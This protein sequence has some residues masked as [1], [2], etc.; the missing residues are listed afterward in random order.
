MSRDNSKSA[1]TLINSQPRQSPSQ[2]DEYYK[3]ER[4]ELVRRS[5]GTLVV[6]MI[7]QN[8]KF[9]FEPNKNYQEARWFAWLKPL[10]NQ[11]LNGI[12]QLNVSLISI[13]NVFRRMA[14]NCI[15]PYNELRVKINWRDKKSWRL[16]NVWNRQANTFALRNCEGFVCFTKTR[17]KYDA[18]LSKMKF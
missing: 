10:S 16:V 17:K 9:Y 6:A 3:T 18:H 5:P 7:L 8:T 14:N 11:S 4:Q 2:V 15:F 13:I 12:S 1:R